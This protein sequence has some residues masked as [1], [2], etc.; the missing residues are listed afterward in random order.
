MRLSIAIAVETKSLPR[1][2]WLYYL[3]MA[4]QISQL[5]KKVRDLELLSHTNSHLWI[6]AL[7]HPECL[8]VQGQASHLSDILR[9]IVTELE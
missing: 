8:S 9:D 7:K 4:E 1:D 3:D 2:R 6:K 5:I